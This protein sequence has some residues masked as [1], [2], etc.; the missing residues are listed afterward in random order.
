MSEFNSNKDYYSILG[1]QEGTTGRDLDGCTNAK[2]QN[3]IPI[4]GRQLKKK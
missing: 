3:F 1:A 4:R 2:Q